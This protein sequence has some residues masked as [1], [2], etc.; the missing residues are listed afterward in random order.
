M[1]SI[2]ENGMVLELTTIQR[3]TQS[4]IEYWKARYSF[5]TGLGTARLHGTTVA[6]HL[7]AAAAEYDACTLARA[8]GWGSSATPPADLQ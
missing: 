3:R 6:L 5:H 7:S 2:I 8:Q 1:K 4:G